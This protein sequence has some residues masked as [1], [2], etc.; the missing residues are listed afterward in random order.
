MICRNNL[1]FVL[2]EELYEKIFNG[3]AVLFAGAGVSTEGQSVFPMTFFEI[4]CQHVGSDPKTGIKFPDAMTLVESKS[5][6]ATLLRMIHD[7][8]AYFV[9]F[10]ELYRA[11]TRFHRELSTIYLIDTVFTTNW[12]DFFEAECGA[13][14][15]VSADDFA[16][17]SLPGR[18]VFKLHGSVNSYGSIVAT[19]KDYEESY[20]RL[21]SELIGANLKMMLATKT[22]V[23][24]GFSFTDDDLLRIQRLL[25]SEMKGMLPR[26]YIVTLDKASDARFRAEGLLPIYTD[27]TFFL[28]EVKR[29]L[30]STH[31]MLADERFRG[32]EQF[33]EEMIDRHHELTAVIDMRKH[34]ELLYCSHYQ[35]GLIHALDRILALRKTGR[36]SNGGNALGTEIAYQKLRKERVKSGSYSDVAYIDG[37]LN[38][39]LFLVTDDEFRKT[40]PRYYVYADGGS[41]LSLAAYKRVAKKAAKLHKGA[42]KRAKETIEH[43]LGNVILH[44]I[45]MI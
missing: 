27:A 7:R 31:R 42:M 41:I 3:D 22:I 8:F 24:M 39:H 1:P 17:W 16:F 34:P 38:G 33:L 21:K 40:V 4:A 14:P 30:V 35:D 25:S 6:R 43:F 44:H 28:S 29:R 45:P 10:P 5:G 18:K 26:S 11:A 9:G 13:L 12:D 32:V 20:K 15:F 36:Y 23:Y 37:Y 19:R 2:P